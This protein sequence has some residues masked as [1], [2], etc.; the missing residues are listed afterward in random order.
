MSRMN[1]AL[2]LGGQQPDLVNALARG[3]QARAVADANQRQNALHNVYQTHG[4]GI[5]RGD[6]AS[7]NA[8]AKVNPVQAQEIRSRQELMDQRRASQKIEFDRYARALSAE[9]AAAE[10]AEIQRTAHKIVPL[11]RAGD[12]NGVNQVLTELGEPTVGSIEDVPF[13]L[14]TFEDAFTALKNAS[15]MTAEP[16]P[17]DE[18][19]RYVAEERAAGRTPLSRLE[20]AQAKKGK[21]FSLEQGPDGTMRV[22]FGGAETA[23]GDNKVPTNQ[24]KLG[25]KIS[26]KDAAAL[27]EAEEQAAASDSLNLN[28]SEAESVMATG[29]DTGLGSGVKKFVSKVGAAAGLGTGE[30]AENYEDLDRISKGIGI[31]TLRAMGGNDTERELLTAIQTTVSPQKEEASNKRVIAR[32]KA[33]AD[34]IAEKPRLMA[35]WIERYGSLSNPNPSGEVWSTYWRSQQLEMF[36][37]LSDRY[38][39]EL[40]VQRESKPEQSSGVPEVGATEDGYRFNGG[41]PSDPNN[42]QKVGG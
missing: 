3:Q 20:F 13:A 6:Q 37:G 31:D 35:A 33:A 38:M 42:W 22:S 39:A 8:L 27:K 9:Q 15:E 16:E 17:A 10:A 19:G 7:I 12:L 14:A 11:Y 30:N 4:E 40:G 25:T 29:I 5:A 1:A 32:Q 34:T 28:I 21:G 26:E 23:T 41:D 36:N 24:D 2:I 18:Y